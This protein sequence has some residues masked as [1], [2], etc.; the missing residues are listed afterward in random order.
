LRFRG[1]LYALRRSRA[2]LVAMSIDPQ[3][4][5]PPSGTPPASSP[6]P[7]RGR[8]GRL[9]FGARKDPLAPGGWTVAGVPI[10]RPF[11]LLTLV[12]EGVLLFV[13]AQAGFLDGP[14]VLANMAVD[15]W[16]PH[17]FY[18]LS[19]RLVTQNGI[20]LM[21]SAALVT[22]LYTGGHVRLLVVLYSI[23]VFLTFSRTRTC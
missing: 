5:P 10:G 19:D 15:S 2:R 22:L 4:Q 13:A 12:S 16:V 11:L 17:R 23:N 20:V 3:A 6:A 1:S 7:A 14:R 21:G 9:L 8:V 18:Q